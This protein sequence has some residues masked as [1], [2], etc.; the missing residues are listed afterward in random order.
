MRLTN[1][2]DYSLRVL[3]YLAAKE[4]D[5]LSNIKEIA[6]AYQ[7]S[8][9]HLMKVTY[10]LGKL[11]VIETIRGRGGGI[12]LAKDPSE[13]NIGF[14]VRQTEDDFSLVECFDPERNACT[15]SPACTL[16]GVLHKALQAYFEVL[17]GYT[18]ADLV[19][20]KPMLVRLLN[21][22]EENC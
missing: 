10:E 7:I 12:R 1:Y 8:K 6:E 13:I 21:N 5:N 2:T 16:K 4:K 22:M 3:I 15:I 20:N 11:N 9:N 17:D 14:I 18:L 19:K